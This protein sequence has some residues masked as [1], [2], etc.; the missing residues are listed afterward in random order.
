MHALDNFKLTGEK[1]LRIIADVLMV[2]GA[3][4]AALALRYFYLVAFEVESSDR[5]TRIFW[6]YVSGYRSSAW[7]LTLICLVVFFASG[8]YS[9]GRR[10]AGRYKALIV[11]QAVS[12]SFLLFGFFSYFFGKTLDLPRG[13]LII[14]WLLTTALLIASRVW[15]L[16]WRKM[17]RAERMLMEQPQAQKEGIVLVIGGAGY[18]GSALLPKLL[19]K[20][21][22]VRL[23][24][25]LLYGT[26]PI[27]DSL[28]HPNLEVVRAD[29]R[30]VDKV[31]ECMRGVDSVIH[32][33]AI[34]G[35]PACALDQELTIEINLMATRMIAEVAKGSGVSR[36]I[37]ASTCSVYGANDELLDEHSVLNPVSLYARSKIAS[38]QVL[39]SMANDQFAPTF[40]R[41]GTIYGLSGR[42]RFDLV[43]NLLTAQAI[44]NNEITVFGGDQW[45][46]FLH[47]D[48]AALAVLK[49]L[50]APL[51]QVCNE[52]FNVGSDAQNFTIMQ[53]GEMVNRLVP[54]AKLIDMGADGDRRNYRVNFDKIH[55]TLRFT[56]QWTLDQGIQQVIE[57]IASGKVTDFRDAKYSNVKFLNEVGS[58]QLISRV[59]GWPYELMKEPPRRRATDR[60]NLGIVTPQVETL[61]LSTETAS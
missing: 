54:A 49:T 14:S 44:V 47:V 39:R 59:N 32:L 24:D 53:V 27:Q 40:L 58:N 3:V 56:P 34:V 35:D 23:L 5:Y 19:E 38:E 50:E 57:V 31:V 22:R 1:S 12:L 55:R 10:Y 6:T 52:S 4:I 43:A 29:F 45:R 15:S 8:F 37:F 20:G 11:A 7:L 2:N 21:Y 18:I 60:L 36:F 42:T 26:E 28:D 30:H 48:D 25:L 13:A 61:E 46:P 33:G 17:V 9:Y 41:F 51:E 16:L